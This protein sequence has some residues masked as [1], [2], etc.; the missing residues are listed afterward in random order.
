MLS[1]TRLPLSDALATAVRAAHAA[2]SILQAHAAHRDRLIIDTKAKNDLVSQADRD[3]EMA[4]LEILREQT[5]EFGIVAEESG[6]DSKGLATWYIDPLDGTTN[7]LHGIPH[8]AV[9]IALIAHPGCIVAGDT[10]VTCDTPVVA[11]VYDPNREELFTA[12][13][14]TG[15]WLN[16]Q[17][18]RCTD[19]DSLDNALLATGFPFRDFSFADHYLP[20]LE[21]GIRRTR[22]I[23]R[24]GAAALDLAWVACG[25]FDGYWEMG[26]APWDVAAGTLIVREAGG[27]CQD[28]FQQQP[29]PSTGHVVAS[30]APLHNALQ[31]MIKPCLGYTP[32]R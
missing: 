24:N 25:R 30:N 7:F 5:P 16:Q 23:R 14:G 2:A 9:S 27:I 17:R 19:T 12:M 32:Q 4:A 18:L 10:P 11:V 28:I 8:Y 3:A 6:G 15:A 1:S 29:W 20:T 26:L 13:Y 22:G 31:E 21:T